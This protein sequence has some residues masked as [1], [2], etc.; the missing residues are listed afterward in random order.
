MIAEM[1]ISSAVT[2]MSFCREAAESAA[3]REDTVAAIATWLHV[4]YL[5]YLCLSRDSCRGSAM[6]LSVLQLGV[7]KRT[8]L[9]RFFP[10]RELDMHHGLYVARM[11][12][13]KYVRRPLRCSTK[14]KGFQ[15]GATPLIDF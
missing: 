15:I 8:A 1:K 4:Y 7:S 9:A 11:Q 13:L 5:Q 2:R 14:F 12:R 6:L 10:S 3:W